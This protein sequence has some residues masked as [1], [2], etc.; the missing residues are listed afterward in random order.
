M[1]YY[2]NLITHMHWKFGDHED[3]PEI[4]GYTVDEMKEQMHQD[5]VKQLL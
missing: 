5:Q 4:M 3:E 2:N 1:D